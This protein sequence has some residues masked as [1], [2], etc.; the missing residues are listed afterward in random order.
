M[1]PQ[2]CAL[3][4]CPL[5]QIDRATSE[6]HRSHTHDNVDPGLKSELERKHQV[7][8]LEKFIDHIFPTSFVCQDQ[9]WKD[10][11]DKSCP[12]AY[13]YFGNYE[14]LVKSGAR[15]E[16]RYKSF[17]S[18]A[19]A[20]TTSFQAKYPGKVAR[21]VR[22][23]S[24]PKNYIQGSPSYHAGKSQPGARSSRKPNGTAVFSNINLKRYPLNSKET[25]AE[26]KKLQKAIDNWT[27][28]LLC[29][30]FKK[31]R[32]PTVSPAASAAAIS[33]PSPVTSAAVSIPSPATSAAVSTSSPAIFA[34]VPSA[35]PPGPTSVGP[36]TADPKQHGEKTT[37]VYPPAPSL[38]VSPIDY[39]SPPPPL[40]PLTHHQ[41]QLAS[42]ALETISQVGNR[43]HV[44]GLYV[45][46]TDASLWYYDRSGVI[47]TKVFGLREN[48]SSL[49]KF[50]VALSALNDEDAGFQKDF[51]PPEE[52][53]APPKDL[54]DWKVK[55][56][57]GAEV[58]LKTILD[59]RYGIVGRGTLVYSGSIKW[60]DDRVEDDVVIKLAWQVV[61]R[62]AEWE[63]IKH[64]GNSG[65]YPKHFLVR[66]HGTH[67]GAPLSDGFRGRLEL[68]VNSYEDRRL[69]IMVSER[70]KLIAEL[71][72]PADV[73]HGLWCV[74]EG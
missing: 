42:Y 73:K 29:I 27:A 13:E 49:S 19:N 60:Q 46:D 23:Q 28:S 56:E 54:C 50:I 4:S 44:F 9:E 51:I 40:I 45:E 14:G 31:K 66:L 26:T 25:K 22:F 24:F 7:V 72:D 30:E 68:P 38:R 70:F 33:I 6:S 2:E 5:G 18:F 8:S 1:V 64:M 36:H 57:G 67:E 34:T 21:L 59:S 61:S 20:I 71:E 63:F 32:K 62:T 43:S 58:T 41:T 37:E 52:N 53:C 3:T 55:L 65:V 12:K 17:I 39:K 15:E 16:K 48:L 74:F 35:S 69:R 47:S 10:F 11:I